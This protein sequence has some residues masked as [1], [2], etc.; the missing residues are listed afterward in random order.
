MLPISD[1]KGRQAIISLGCAL[2][3]IE[4]GLAAM[5]CAYEKQIHLSKEQVVSNQQQRILVAEYKILSRTAVEVDF[6]DNLKMYKAL[7]T[8]RVDRGEYDH[9][10]KI[11]SG[12][13]KKIESMGL[14]FGVKTILIGDWGRKVALAELQSQAD[15]FV[16]NNRKFAE[17][18]INDWMLENDSLS[19]LGMPGDTFRLNSEQ[20]SKIKLRFQNNQG[21]ESDD[22][23]GMVQLGKKGI[24]SCQ[25]V[26]LLTVEQ[27]NPVEWLNAGITLEK[28]ALLFESEGIAW[29]VHAGLAEV[30]QVNMMMLRPIAM[31]TKRPVI[32]FRAGYL[33]GNE[34]RAPH[35]PRLAFEKVWSRN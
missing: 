3:N 22:A 4:V 1:I 12:V 6:H 33:K 19:E 28:G 9:D 27:D 7:F 8:R 14:P 10:R 24:L 13:L 20:T 30:S 34:T 29:A 23:T 25:C 2:A 17:E 11:D 5:L 31:T 35:S 26:G 32:L 21:F 16:I 15:S 18:L